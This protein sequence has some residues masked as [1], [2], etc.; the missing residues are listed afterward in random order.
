MVSKAP[1]PV[2][3]TVTLR[4]CVVMVGGCVMTHFS[5]SFHLAKREACRP[6]GFHLKTLPGT[7]ILLGVFQAC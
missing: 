3:F 6:R 2:A 4:T 1:V 7:K 5:L